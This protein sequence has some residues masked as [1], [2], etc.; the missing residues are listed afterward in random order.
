MHNCEIRSHNSEKS[1]EDIA[2]SVS[3]RQW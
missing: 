1:I 2:T 3:C